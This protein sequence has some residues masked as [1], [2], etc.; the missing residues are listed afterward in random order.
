VHLMQMFQLYASGIFVSISPEYASATS[1]NTCEIDVRETNGHLV[2]ALWRWA[3]GTGVPLPHH[4]LPFVSNSDDV[5]C[6]PSPS[7]VTECRLQEC[8]TRVIKTTTQRAAPKTVKARREAEA[9]RAPKLLRRISDVRRH[10]DPCADVL[11]TSSCSKEG[12]PAVA[13]KTTS[14][15]VV[16]RLSLPTTSSDNEH[17]ELKRSSSSLLKDPSSR[18]CS[19]SRQQQS[20]KANSSFTQRVR[21]AVDR[22]AD[23]CTTSTADALKAVPTCSSARQPAT[24]SFCAAT[25]SAP[26]RPSSARSRES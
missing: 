3:V 5:P 17:A 2:A 18:F 22:P 16:R 4:L 12:E 25:A 21:Q 14:K 13:T 10:C 1:E 20:P 7:F 15:F 8:V 11:H 23:S 19:T 24:T 9:A 26:R 6:R